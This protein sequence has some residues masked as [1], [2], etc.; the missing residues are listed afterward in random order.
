MASAQR[1]FRLDAVSA[2]RAGTSRRDHQGCRGVTV[3]AVTARD[4][5]RSAACRIRAQNPRSAMSELAEGLLVCRCVTT[6]F[7]QP[8]AGEGHERTS[9]RLLAH[10]AVANIRAPRGS[11]SD[12]SAPP[13]T[14]NLRQA[15]R[16]IDR[17]R[18]P[19]WLTLQNA[20]AGSAMRAS[21]P[22]LS[23]A[24]CA[25]VS[26]SIR[27]LKNLARVNFASSAGVLSD[28]AC[29]ANTALTI[30]AHM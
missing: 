27:S 4:A 24:R 19:P 1:Q 10:S 23:R 20:S 15:S 16:R 7:G 12:G 8:H 14:G 3:I 30:R 11:A 6:K 21:A 2:S 26:G 13:R 28:F 29:R 22:A 18:R 9:A 17:H 5:D 25:A